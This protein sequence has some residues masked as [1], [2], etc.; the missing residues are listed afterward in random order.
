MPKIKQEEDYPEEDEEDEEP[1]ELE[2][3]EPPKKKLP[4]MPLALKKRSPDPANKEKHKVV[5]KRE[6]KKR[7]N[8]FSQQQAEGIIDSES[9]EVL[10]VSIWEALA[11]IIERLERIENAIGMIAES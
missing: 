9:N 5:E 3:E 4:P 7:Y 6:K 2:F 1:E 10:A 8:A 11:D